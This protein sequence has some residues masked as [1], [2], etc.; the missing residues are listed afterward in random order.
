M[1]VKSVAS[2]FFYTPVIDGDGIA[3]YWT[4]LMMENDK[5]LRQRGRSLL[6][7]DGYPVYYL[8]SWP[9]RKVREMMGVV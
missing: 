3:V 7:V 2:R 1:L 8:I 4:A 6:C 5:R 9:W